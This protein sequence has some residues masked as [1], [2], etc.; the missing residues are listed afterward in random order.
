MLFVFIKYNKTDCYSKLM[1]LVS[2]MWRMTFS[3][4]SPLNYEWL[5]GYCKA[6]TLAIYANPVTSATQI[7]K[8]NASSVTLIL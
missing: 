7:V 3:C 5:L 4:H 6:H 8:C 1:F 2:K